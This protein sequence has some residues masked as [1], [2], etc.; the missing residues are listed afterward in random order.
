MV[1]EEEVTSKEQIKKDCLHLH[2]DVAYNE[3]ELSLKGK[4]SANE[5]LFHIN[6]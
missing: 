1:A 4:T 3:V 6:R 5:G 2:N